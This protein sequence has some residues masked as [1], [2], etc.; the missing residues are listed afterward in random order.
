M[1]K[2]FWKCRAIV[3]YRYF[4]VY[5]IV[6]CHLLCFIAN[7]ELSK[8][9][10]FWG[11]FFYINPGCV[12]Q[13]TICKS[14][15]GPSSELCKRFCLFFFKT[16]NW[17]DPRFLK[18]TLSKRRRQIRHMSGVRCQVSGVICQVSSVTCHQRQQ[19]MAQTLPMLTPSLCTVGWF[20]K[21]EIFVLGNQ[22]V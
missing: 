19:P 3:Y 17:R 7:L 16:I 9:M 21:I 15:D 13:M 5:L 1:G 20:A 12:K 14:R 18:G 22:P 4:W 8:I 6:F 11:C 2:S 10:H